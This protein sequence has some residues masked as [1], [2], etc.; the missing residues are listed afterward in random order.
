[1]AQDTD[2]DTS[3]SFHLTDLHTM[4]VR[5]HEMRNIPIGKIMRIALLAAADGKFALRDKRRS[6]LNLTQEN[7]DALEGLAAEAE[8]QSRHRWWTK[9]PWTYFLRCWFVYEEEF[10]SSLD[11]DASSTL[12]AVETKTKPEATAPLQMAEPDTA[13]RILED[14]PTPRV[15]LVIQA[16]DTQ[17]QVF[18][19]LPAPEQLRRVQN[20][21]KSQ[22]D[23]S[24]TTVSVSERTLRTAKAYRRKHP[25]Q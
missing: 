24:K 11:I 22:S 3:N 6:K 5:T 18:H 15:Q 7:R 19:S 1:M 25:K 16:L 21:V 14:E 20:W 13:T 8:Q 10:F 2:Q 12:L 9:P 17:D 23:S 4:I